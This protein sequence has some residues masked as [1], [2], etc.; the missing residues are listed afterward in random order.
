MSECKV[1]PCGYHCNCYN[2]IDYDKL[3]C[4]WC[5]LITEN[6]QREK[7][8]VEDRAKFKAAELQISELKKKLEQI[9]ELHGSAV[10]ECNEVNR[11]IDEIRKTAVPFLE[12]MRQGWDSDHYEKMLG[13]LETVLGLR[14]K[15]NCLSSCLFPRHGQLS[16]ELE[17]GHDGGHRKT[18]NGHPFNW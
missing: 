2:D 3:G 17:A 10:V 1:G 14:A 13:P 7:A 12:R 15:R 18:V 11:L 6:E 4:Q 8:W 5:Q 16:C 9:H